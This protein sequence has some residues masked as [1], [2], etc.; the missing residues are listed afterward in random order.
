MRVREQV[1]LARQEE[2]EFSKGPL[3]QSCHRVGPASAALKRRFGTR[4]KDYLCAP[5]FFVFFLQISLWFA[6]AVLRHFFFHFYSFFN[7]YY[8]STWSE[9]S[10]AQFFSFSLYLT[11]RSAGWNSGRINNSDRAGRNWDGGCK[12]CFLHLPL[13]V[14]RNVEHPSPLVRPGVSA[15]VIY[16][17]FHFLFPLISFQTFI[18]KSPLSSALMCFETDLKRAR[19]SHPGARKVKKKKKDAI[20]WF[21]APNVPWR[22]VCFRIPAVVSIG[23]DCRTCLPAASVVP[24]CNMTQRQLD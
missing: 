13:P 22:I 16:D 5:L 10:C 17:P 12:L 19:P 23:I 3:S 9:F 6:S 24:L 20:C 1:L 2:R 14:G 4:S 18:A 7:Y 15:S 8:Y 21:P 11:I